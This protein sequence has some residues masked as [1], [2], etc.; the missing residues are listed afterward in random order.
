VASLTTP[1]VSAW[2]GGLMC[3][4]A[5][6]ATCAVL[7]GF[8]RYRAGAAPPREPAGSSLSASETAR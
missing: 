5:V 8:V 1:A 4:A 6:A 7:P 3:I 2:A